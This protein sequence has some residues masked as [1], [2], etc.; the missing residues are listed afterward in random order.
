MIKI[1]PELKG[2]LVFEIKS[3][4]GRIF[5]R[6]R[7]KIRILNEPVLMDVGAGTNYRE[8]WI[9]VDFFLIRNPFK[10]HKGKSKKTPEVQMDLRFPFKCTD[11][12]IDGIYSSHTLEHFSYAEANQ[13]LKEFFRMLK[14]G[15]WLRLIVPDLE[16]YIEFYLGKNNDLPYKSGCEA[17]ASLTQEWGHK[18]VWDYARLSKQLESQGFSEVKKLEYGL[19]GTDKRLI[20]DL[21]SRKEESLV[22]EAQKPHA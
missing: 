11:A 15:G 17:I 20:K 7:S 6:N 10:L 21:A 3:W 12:Q 4:Y 14:P 5:L 2:Q 1:N 9:H 13:L 16:T 8:G 22:I 18:S 19:E